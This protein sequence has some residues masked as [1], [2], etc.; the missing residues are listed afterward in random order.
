MLL[1]AKSSVQYS[2]VSPIKRP[3]PEEVTGLPRAANASPMQLR[4]MEV[5][6]QVDLAQESVHKAITG[7]ESSARARG[8][9]NA[10]GA[11][12]RSRTNS[13]CK[14]EGVS[15]SQANTP[16]RGVSSRKETSQPLQAGDGRFPHIAEE[17]EDEDE[18][19]ST[20]ENWLTEQKRGVTTR[21]KHGHPLHRDD[22]APTPIEEECLDGYTTQS[23]YDRDSQAKG[24]SPNEEVRDEKMDYYISGSLDDTMY[25]HE[26]TGEAASE[27][28]TQKMVRGKYLGNDVEVVGLQCMLAQALMGDGD[29]E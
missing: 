12:G 24:S 25:D 17:E 11:S 4:L 3:N 5:M 14:A 1:D 22:E 19:T 28:S 9:S 15:S 6:S 8:L 2:V 27:Q 21:R 20:L 23:R 29:E 16:Q 26:T 18:L 13:E 10:D 7:S